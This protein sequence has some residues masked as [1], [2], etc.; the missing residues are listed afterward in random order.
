MLDNKQCEAFLAVV[1]TGSFELAGA[2][3]HVTPSAITL[4]V[5][6]L[7]QCVG[8]T[9]LLRERPC[10]P[11]Q[12]GHE[13]LSYLRK[14]KLLE[15]DL[16]YQFSGKDLSSE[17]FKLAI[18]I[19]ADTLATWFLPALQQVTLTEKILLNLQLEDQ[20]YTHYLLETGQVNACISTES[21]ARS[22][23]YATFLGKVRYHLVAS[24]AFI[25]RWFP[26]GISREALKHA[27]AVIF[28]R[29]DNMHGNVLLE[30]FGLPKTA[31]PYHFIPSSE[32]FVDAIEL[33]LG[34][35]MVPELQVRN[36]ELVVLTPKTTLDISLYWHHWQQQ[37]PQLERLTH[38]LI[39]KSQE[40]LL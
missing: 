4:R 40:F 1:E 39:I 21:K 26:Y 14:V 6:A 24:D 35:G 30:H 27:P 7:E 36:T 13:L 2:Q 9:L 25:R 32:S 37:S 19:N 17:F 38:H 8:K 28:N 12:S 33:G 18:A 3:L 15:Q 16:L 31:Y 22:G 29:K 20:D 11:T 5:K 23:C 34:Y 10:K